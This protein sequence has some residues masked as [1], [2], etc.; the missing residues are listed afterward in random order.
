MFQTF[1]GA[2][3][4]IAPFG[5]VYCFDDKI[6]AF[7]RIFTGLAAFHIFT[8]V[9]F[10]YFHIFTYTLVLAT[11]I[12]LVSIC[13]IFF[14]KFKK[15]LYIKI[16][17][18]F[19]FIILLIFLKLFLIN[20]YYTGIVSTINGY[21]IV[22]QDE[23]SYPSFSDEWIGA[24]LSRDS[25]ENNSLPTTNSLYYSKHFKN[26]LFIFFSVLAHFFLLLNL[27]PITNYQVMSIISGLVVCLLVFTI[28]RINK[29]GNIGSV[30]GMFSV[31]LIVNGANL[32]GIWF[33]IPFISGLIMFLI[34]LSAFG[35]KDKNTF[36][37]SSFLSFLLYPPIIIFI[38]PTI[39]FSL[40]HE[41]SKINFL[42][43]LIFSAL[44]P[45][46]LFL[47]SYLVFG[48]TGPSF[49]ISQISRNN[50]EGGIP[51]FAIW[52]VIPLY[53]L[54]FSIIGFWD[55]F[56]N[57]DFS[58]LAPIV[59]G[60]I[61][62][63][64]YTT[65]TKVFL[66]DYPRVV[67]ITSVL[68]VLFAGFG[69]DFIIKKLKIR[70]GTS[71]NFSILIIF[72]IFCLVQVNFYPNDSWKNLVLKINNNGRET[73]ISPASPMNRYLHE[74]DLRIFSNIKNKTFVAPQWKGLVLGVV[75]E[76]YPTES[77]PSI[78]SNKFLRY[79]RFIKSDCDQKK[80][81][82]EKAKVDYVYSKEFSCKNFVFIASSTEGLFLYKFNN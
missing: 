68:I 56:K 1:L 48:K 15:K 66:I 39:L 82:A 2:I 81:M 50:L 33:L 72:I 12:F 59:S 77:K 23:Y 67:V 53:V 73:K 55:R 49:I 65:T 57:K 14:L 4:L 22:S 47:I 70:E 61:F 44:I 74:D 40:F 5:L 51:S 18:L 7:I 60:L 78:V 31:L 28:L 10:Q 76:N 75:T 20:F 24:M 79:D 62:W 13:I 36:L 16:N 80:N 26:L 41:R 42:K 45:T 25:I 3:I 37:I 38:I 17:W 21:K 34:S 30:F 43:V 27:D 58:I 69:F 71:E 54:F 29:V 35:L 11:N 63:I 19:I 6:K 64:I 52:N 9:I 8:A 46:L 32:P